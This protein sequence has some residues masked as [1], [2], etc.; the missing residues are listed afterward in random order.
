MGDYVESSEAWNALVGLIDCIK[1]GTKCMHDFNYESVD[2][3][4]ILI[5]LIA[6]G[7]KKGIMESKKV[8]RPLSDAE[9]AESRLNDPGHATTP[10]DEIKRTFGLDKE[11][12]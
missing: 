1:D 12:K 2:V 4:A 6:E 5:D 3:R 10:W 9:I 8:G 11:V 7:V